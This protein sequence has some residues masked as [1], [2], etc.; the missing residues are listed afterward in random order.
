MN[1][2]LFFLSTLLTI[3]L[4]SCGGAATENKSLIATLFPQYS[5]ANQLAGDLLDVEFLLPVGSDPHDF[6]PTPSQRVKLNNADVVLFTSESFEA[7]IHD[8][9][10]TAK[11]K[12][13]DLS[14]FVT[15]IEIDEH[16]HD[17]LFV[18]PKF[19]EGHDDEYDPHYWLDPMNGLAMLEVIA[20]EILILV[21]EHT[22]LVESRKQLIKNALEDV[23]EAYEDIVQEGEEL[24][25]I[26][27][28]HNAF[29][30]LS[31]Y[32]I[33]VFTPYPG[34]SSDTVPTA[35]SLINFLNLIKELGTN[36]LFIST[37]DNNA[38]IDALLEANSN[39]E[40]ELLYTLENVS[41][42]QFDLGVSYQELLMINYDSISQSEK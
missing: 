7:W 26:F 33:H 29:G 40:T 21:P 10:D 38:V 23:V 12:L 16:D 36:I 13:V 1:K 14:T 3:S 5:L 20:D 32:H 18:G 17:H 9:E 25:I 42:S 2:N 28:G 37:T 24:D 34:F 15:L 19:A 22:L 35:E 8:I 4:A 30:Y 6:E 31:I 39:L 41:Q 27:A 11:G